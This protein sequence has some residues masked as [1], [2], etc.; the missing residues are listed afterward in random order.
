MHA[1]FLPAA[2]AIVQTLDAQ[3]LRSGKK[4]AQARSTG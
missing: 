4:T 1:D 2:E 3:F